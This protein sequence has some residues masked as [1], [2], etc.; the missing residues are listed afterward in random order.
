MSDK[1]MTMAVS[2]NI[3][4]SVRPCTQSRP[5]RER[6][7]HESSV[8]RRASGILP[9]M[10]LLKIWSS[11]VQMKVTATTLVI[12]SSLSRD[13][14]MYMEPT[15][16]RAPS[17][18]SFG[19]PA[20]RMIAAL[21]LHDAVPRRKPENWRENTSASSEHHA[22]P[23]HRL[24]PSRQQSTS[25]P[26]LLQRVHS[27]SEAVSP[28]DSRWRSSAE[29]GSPKFVPPVPAKTNSMESS[30][31]DT[32]CQRITMKLKMQSH[33]NAEL[34]WHPAPARSRSMVTQCK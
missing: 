33:C 2:M 31:C 3:L 12:T 13:V 18:A 6:G 7:R 25:A 4:Q 15:Y 24:Q 16:K 20:K 9:E 34:Q 10:K 29:G 1:T 26:G 8:L 23:Q 14:A 5:S 21:A 30:V 27:R 22:A 11:R 17:I 19:M 28:V 32:S